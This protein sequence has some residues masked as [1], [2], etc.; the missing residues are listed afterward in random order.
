MIQKR[1][2]FR[3]AAVPAGVHDDG[4]QRPA[5]SCGGCGKAA[6]RGA[7]VAGLDADGTVIGE[8][9]LIGIRAG[10]IFVRAFV[11]DLLASGRTICRNSLFRRAYCAIFAM[12]RAVE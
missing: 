2:G 6:L 9:E 10:E 4:D 1:G 5:I 11:V 7:G 8:E 3:E 12:S